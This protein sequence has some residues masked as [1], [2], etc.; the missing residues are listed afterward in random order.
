MHAFSRYIIS[1]FISNIA[2]CYLVLQRLAVSFRTVFWSNKNQFRREIEKTFL[3]RKYADRFQLSC[4][5]SAHSMYF[6]YSSSIEWMVSI[7]LPRFRAYWMCTV[8]TIIGW[9]AVN[10]WRL[11]TTYV[12]I[13][14]QTFVLFIICYFKH[15][16]PKMF[17]LI[18]I[19]GF[20][21]DWSN[22]KRND[23]IS[24]SPQAL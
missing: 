4:L 12:Q 14:R 5:L 22:V 2:Y 18:Y 20:N 13:N 15:R 6:F 11:D 19:L 10:G 23:R 24:D 17:Y 7:I 3:H 21:F 9:E 8:H 16:L 1:F